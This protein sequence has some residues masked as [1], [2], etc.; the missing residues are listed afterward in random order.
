M[1]I[2]K[3]QII[4]YLAENKCTAPMPIFFDAAFCLRYKGL[5]P[6]SGS[7]L[8]GFAIKGPID[9]AVAFVDVNDDGLLQD[10][11]PYA[12]TEAD[13][14]FTIDPA[15]ETGDLIVTTD[16]A[17]VAAAGFLSAVDTSSSTSLS[18]VTLSAPTGA[19]V[20]S[21]TSTLINE[22]SL[23]EA[24]VKEALGLTGVS[25][26]LFQPV[27]GWSGASLALEV[28]KAATQ[29]MTTVNQW[30][31]LHKARAGM[32]RPVSLLRWTSL[33]LR[34]KTL[35]QMTVRWILEIQLLLILL[36]F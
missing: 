13:G 10:D 15:G 19:T 36:S 14:S 11:E 31:L 29:V 9:G 16:N 35:R 12:F 1:R 33:W 8:S 24:Q 21:P 20:V 23:S 4:N 5:S 32:L 7:S 30:L 27:R 25:D 18:N 22:S 26:L 17:V 34:L 6:G 3:R 28:E 2:N